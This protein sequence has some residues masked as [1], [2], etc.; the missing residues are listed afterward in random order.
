MKNL[1]DHVGLGGRAGMVLSI[2]A[3]VGRPRLKGSTIPGL[4]P[5]IVQ[6]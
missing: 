2:F 1:L 5:S 3:N 6:N 4:G